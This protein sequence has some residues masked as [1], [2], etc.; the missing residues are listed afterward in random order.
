MNDLKILFEPT[1]EK[2]YLIID[3]PAGLPSAPLFPED[4]DNML[5]IA[6]K[7]FPQ[8]QNVIGKKKIE[9]GLL[10]RLDTPT[11]GLILIACKQDFYDYMQDLQQNG[12]FIKYYHAV[13]DYIPDNAEKLEGFA[14]AKKIDSDE[15]LDAEKNSIIKAESYFRPYGKNGKEVRPVTEDSGMAALKKIGKKTLYST[16][17]KILKIK[18][19]K[20]YVGCNG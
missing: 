19:G 12:Q 14:N 15:I 11:A 7:S 17:V 8:I 4:N 10:H 6:C 9:Y 2:P 5:S 18:D 3:K 20:V 16:D 1:D 13:C